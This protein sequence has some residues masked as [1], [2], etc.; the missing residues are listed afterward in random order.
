M[1][2]LDGGHYFLT[3]LA[4]IRVGTMIDPVIGRSR[5]HRHQLAQKLALLA[6]GRQTAVSPADAWPSPFSRNLL[7]HLV[8]FVIID[9][10][11]FNGRHAGDTILELLRGI[12]PLEP[13]PVD[14]L[15]TPYLLFAA[16]I[17]AP[18]DGDALRNYTEVLWETMEDD[19][20]VIFGHCI[21]FEN[22]DSHEKFLDYIRKCQIETT[23][24][25]NDYW[26]DG[27]SAVDSRLPMI[28]LK[29]AGIVAGAGLTIWLAALLLHGIFAMFGFEGRLAEQVT[30]V[31]AWG[32]TIMPLLIVFAL[33]GLYAIYKWILRQG[34][35]PLP[36]APDSAL[37]SI[38]EALFIQQHFTEFVIKMQGLDD[39]TLYAHF[40]RFLAKIKPANPEPT[41][42]PGSFHAPP[43]E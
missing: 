40:D 5:S 42:P 39:S 3:V 4:P 2:N 19:L 36:T 35:K 43:R 14:R 12:N 29:L 9:G 34:A 38:L 16:D 30:T 26:A 25:F 1:P 18:E 10:P 22:V 7:N 17:D 6:T 33:I 8:R 15:S 32:L 23:M 24:P 21:G 28:G 37:P 41:Q 31:T 27:L 11:A 20:K 13:Q